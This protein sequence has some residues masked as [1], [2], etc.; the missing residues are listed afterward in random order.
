MS[1][2]VNKVIVLK[3]NANWQRVGYGSVGD[4][5]VDLCAGISCLAIDVQYAMD[6]DG[7][8]NLDWPSALVPVDWETWITLPIYPWQHSIKSTKMEIRVPTVLIAK[9]FYKMPTKKFKKTPSKDGVK[10]RD[11]N[12]DQY[13]G[14]LLQGD[15]VTLD[16]VIPVSKGGKDT[17]ENLVC[18]SKKTNSMKGNKLN[19][20]VGL[21]LIRKP[22]RPRDIPVSSLIREAR[23]P[24]WRPFLKDVLHV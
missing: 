10:I 2:I 6:E 21:T 11:G 17:W 5:I 14:K 15:D 23:H 16:H 4:A 20:E 18:T 7:N 24:D 9:N 13:S 22:G 19:S 3:L 1:N 8:P 12:I